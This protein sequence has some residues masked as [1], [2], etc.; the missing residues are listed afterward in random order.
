MKNL[1]KNKTLV[2]TALAVIIIIAVICSIFFL[3]EKVSD[4]PE[5]DNKFA[6]DESGTGVTDVQG[7]T[8]STDPSGNIV[9]QDGTAYETDAKGN[10]WII[11]DA[12]PS[13]SDKVSDDTWGEGE[14]IPYPTIEDD[15]SESENKNKPTSGSEKD[16]EPTSGSETERPDPTENDQTIP[17]NATGGIELPPVPFGK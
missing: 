1:F 5:P 13:V 17:T 14:F 8:Y 3:K 9:S 4:K 16:N 11:T 7:N 15:P 12:E 10:G 6:S 2:F